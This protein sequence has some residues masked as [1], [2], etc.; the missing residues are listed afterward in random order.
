MSRVHP[1]TAQ[2]RA[3]V[4]KAVASLPVDTILK[5]DCVA[6]MEA[7]PEH[8]VDMIFADPPYNLQL[9]G[10]SPR[11]MLAMTRGISFRPLSIMTRSQLPGF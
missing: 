7:L 4:K 1:A 6:A 10:T 11:S 8:S 9:E 5:G 3:R 2:A